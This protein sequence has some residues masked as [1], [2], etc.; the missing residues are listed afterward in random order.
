MNVTYSSDK[1][2]P[3]NKYENSLWLPTLSMLSLHRMKTVLI[4]KKKK[5]IIHIGKFNVVQKVLAA[6]S[7]LNKFSRDAIDSCFKYLP[8]FS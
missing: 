2:D 3:F 8:I 7:M 1:D 6:S 5:K 4:V